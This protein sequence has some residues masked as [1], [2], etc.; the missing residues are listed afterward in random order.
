MQECQENCHARN[1]VRN[2]IIACRTYSGGLLL[3]ERANL[4]EPTTIEKDDKL[5]IRY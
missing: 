4:P 3:V 1:L 5:G 2:A